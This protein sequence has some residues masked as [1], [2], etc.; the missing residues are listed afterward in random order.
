M[1]GG[2][3]VTFWSPPLLRSICWG[4]ESGQPCFL[5]PGSLNYIAALRIIINVSRKSP[6]GQRGRA[7]GLHQGVVVAN[8]PTLGSSLPLSVIIPTHRRPQSLAKVLRALA[9]QTFSARDFEVVVVIDGPD[10][11]TER[12]LEGSSF[13]FDIRWFTQPARGATAARNLGVAEARSELLVFLAV[14]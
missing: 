4:R 7:L 10:P 14:C 13:P 2:R 3:K 8:S 12:I 9:R 5:D 11:E 6:T 1:G